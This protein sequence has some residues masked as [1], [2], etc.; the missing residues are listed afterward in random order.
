MPMIRRDHAAA[1][2]EANIKAKWRRT[3]FRDNRQPATKRRPLMLGTP[4]DLRCW[5]HEPAGHDWPGKNNGQPHP[6]ATKE[7]P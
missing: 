7:R 2:V 4:D 3:H 6:R 5:C 1:A